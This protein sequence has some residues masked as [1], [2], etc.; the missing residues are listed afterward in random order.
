MG[1][2]GTGLYDDDSAPP[3]GPVRTVSGAVHAWPDVPALL[4]RPEAL[5][6]AAGAMKALLLKI[7]K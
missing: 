2:W 1:S 6:K 7:S 3:T 4:D 5:V